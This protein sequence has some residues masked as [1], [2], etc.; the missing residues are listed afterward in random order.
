MRLQVEITTA[1]CTDSSARSSASTDVA[2]PSGMRQAL[3]QRQRRGVVRDAEGQEGLGH[4]YRFD[5]WPLTV[6][7]RPSG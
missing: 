1:S 2:R 3:A 6:P 5:L 7:A 4:R